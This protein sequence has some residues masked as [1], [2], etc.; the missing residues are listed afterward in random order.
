MVYS[1]ALLSFKLMKTT[2]SNNFL[3][4]R[5]N[6]T[7]KKRLHTLITYK[8]LE[9]L[10]IFIVHNI[11]KMTLKYIVTYEYVMSFRRLV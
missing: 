2:W 1:I 8:F 11:L 4:L 5:N 3:L 10:Q 9:S 7:C 6:K